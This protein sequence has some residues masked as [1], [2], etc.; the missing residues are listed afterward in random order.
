MTMNITLGRILRVISYRGRYTLFWCSVDADGEIIKVHS[1]EDVD[2][3]FR[4]MDELK[5]VLALIAEARA[6][7]VFVITASTKSL[8]SCEE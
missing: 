3:S 8:L 5:D 1:G 2:T 4:S 6:M 7:P